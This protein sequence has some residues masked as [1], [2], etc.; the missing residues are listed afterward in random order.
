MPIT[1]HYDGSARLRIHVVSGRPT[2][3]EF[4]T[5]IVSVYEGGHADADSL[6]D[7]RQAR[8][9]VSAADVRR[10]RATVERYRDARGNSRQAVVTGRDLDFAQ[11]RMFEMLDDWGSAEFMV[12]R[13]IGAA[14]GWL[15]TPVDRIDGRV[16]STGGLAD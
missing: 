11:V 5:T 7:M 9:E 1:T 3:E 2:A 13:D 6:W 15:D 10:L 4:A 8:L 14:A 12:F 16:L